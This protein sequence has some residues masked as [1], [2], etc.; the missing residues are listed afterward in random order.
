MAM[1]VS[2]PFVG[3]A[4]LADG[5][6]RSELFEETRHTVCSFDLTE[7]KLRLFWR[8][9]SERPYRAFSALARAVER[10]GN[11]LTFAMNAGM[12]QAD[13][14]PVGLY[15]EDG[16]E[17]RHLNE[18]DSPAG[19]RPTPNFYRKPNG[20]FYIRGNEAGVLTTEQFLK[21]RPKV[22]YATQSGPML[23]IDGEL[24]PAFIKGSSDRT[25]RTGVCVTEPGKV[26]FAISDEQI[27]F[28]DFAR[29]FRNRLGCRNALFLDGGNGAGLYA[30]ELARNDSSWHG[31][32][33]PIFGVVG[34][35]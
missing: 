24:H 21:I 2:L 28:Y 13:F 27:N 20:V 4:A 31:G 5:P 7:S 1:F 34:R 23:V 33:G 30:P 3:K 9:A 6:C 12:F 15:V 19:I 14:A 17:F 26:S 16:R 10:N 18:T 29:F 22:D 35:R 8:D 25:R 11:V 32:F